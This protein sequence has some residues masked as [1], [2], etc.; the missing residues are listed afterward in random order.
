MAWNQRSN[1][2]AENGKLVA[3]ITIDNF[4]RGI[5][6]EVTSI[7]LASGTNDLV[8]NTNAGTAGLFAQLD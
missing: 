2:Q 7:K 4:L 5:S 3:A 6:L 1:F 8:S